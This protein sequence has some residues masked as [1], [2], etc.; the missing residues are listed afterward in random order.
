MLPRA[1]SSACPQKRAGGCRE[2]F[3]SGSTVIQLKVGNEAQTTFRIFVFFSSWT[4]VELPHHVISLGKRISVSVQKTAYVALCDIKMGPVP[5]QWVFS[6]HL[7][8]TK[9]QKRDFSVSREFQ[10]GSRHF[11]A[12]EK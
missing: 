1:V 7:L 2:T 8:K 11:S 4:P 3:H 9:E 10:A 6:A 5:E 12:R